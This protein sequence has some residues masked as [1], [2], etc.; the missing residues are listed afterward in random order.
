MRPAS[1][2]Y[3]GGVLGAGLGGSVAGPVGATLGGL[4][5][6]GIGHAVN[7]RHS[8]RVMKAMTNKQFVD[9]LIRLGRIPKTEK[10][11]LTKELNSNP[12]LKTELINILFKKD[13]KKNN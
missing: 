4:A 12:V 2:H 13:D 9:E 11:H 6:A 1:L 5:G 8:A 10:Q 3:S 7:V